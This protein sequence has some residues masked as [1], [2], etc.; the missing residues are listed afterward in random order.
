MPSTT[1]PA[2]CQPF[3]LTIVVLGLCVTYVRVCGEQVLEL[4]RAKLTQAQD[5]ASAVQLSISNL[6]GALA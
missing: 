1:R 6:L 3:C 5:E 4:E 2:T